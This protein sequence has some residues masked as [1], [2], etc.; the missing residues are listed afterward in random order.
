MRVV[1]LPKEVFSAI[2]R[3]LE[4]PETFLA[5][6]LTCRAARS[7]CQ[8]IQQFM[9][10]KLQYV[11]VQ[12]STASVSPRDRW[13]EISETE[14]EARAMAYKYQAWEGSHRERTL[15]AVNFEYSEG[16]LVIFKM[17]RIDILKRLCV[18]AD[19]SLCRSCFE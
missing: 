7:G 10:H 16:K 18:I 14:G 19:S 11:Y 17:R 8:M 2:G 12:I 6:A 4:S 13:I 15:E 5:L 3:Y 1:A 9:Q